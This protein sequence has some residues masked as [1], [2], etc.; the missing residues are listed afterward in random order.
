MGYR[1]RKLSRPPAVVRR[2]RAT[3][4]GFAGHKWPAGHLFGTPAL[5]VLLAG[6]PKLQQCVSPRC[7][8][9]FAAVCIPGPDL[10]RKDPVVLGA[11]L[12]STQEAFRF[13]EF[14]RGHLGVLSL[15]GRQRTHWVT[16]YG[17]ASCKNYHCGDQ[18]PPEM[19]FQPL[20]VLSDRVTLPPDTLHR[21]ERS[22]VP[23]TQRMVQRIQV[24][25]IRRVR[26]NFC[27][28]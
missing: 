23:W 20:T 5:R 14:L 28:R 11:A 15:A 10:A 13:L 26:S 22:S 7:G 16:A 9:P 3:E 18:T 21:I 2:P 24:T 4:K 25:R 1:L 19:A 8:R 27:F 6:T 17:S 12:A